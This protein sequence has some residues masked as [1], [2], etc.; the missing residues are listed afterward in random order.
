[1]IDRV[2]GNRYRIVERIGIGGMA[3]VYRAT[4]EVL[5]RTVAVKVMLPQYAADPTFAARFKQ[6]AQAAANLQS[7]Y[8]VSI[9]D[10]GR[11]DTDETYYIVM[12]LVRGTDLK[13]AINQRG[14]LN[15]RKAAEI[16]SQVCS[17]LS[18]AHAYDIIHRD[19]KPHNIMVQPDGNAKV[20]DFGIA[21]ANGSSMTQTGSVLGTAYYVSP[22]QAQGR[23]LTAATDLYSLGIVLYECV[24]GKLPFEGPDAVAVALKQVNQAPA[25]P[26][27]LNADL[28]ADLEAI[29]LKAMAKDPA[30]R[31]ST[32]EAMRLALNNY[33]AGRPIDTGLVDPQAETSVIAAANRKVNRGDSRGENRGEARVSATA[34]TTVLRGERGERAGGGGSERGGGGSDRSGSER[35]SG[36][37]PE[38]EITRTTIMP[39]APVSA[40]GDLGLVTSL[41][42]TRKKNRNR[43]IAVGV[44]VCVVI[45]GLVA[46][47]VFKSFQKNT[48]DMVRVP[49]V[50][51]RTEADAIKTLKDA[52]FEVGET[53]YEYSETVDEG[54]VISTNPAARELVDKGSEVDLVVSKGKPE[55][56]Q[57][58]VP[59]VV[60][61]TEEEARKKIEDAGFVADR[62]EEFSST[63]EAGRITR[64]DPESDKMAKTGTTITYWVSKGVESRTVP[65]VIG[66]PYDEAVRILY[67]ENFKVEKVRTE[68]S[69]T[70]P[71]D[72]VISQDP[73]SGTTQKEGTVIKL[74][75]SDGPA[76]PPPV[77]I[78]DIV[79]MTP[80]QAGNTLGNLGLYVDIVYV[81]TSIP[82]EVGK[83]LYCDPGVDSEVQRGTTVKLAVGE[84]PPDPPDPPPV[85]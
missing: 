52:G 68:Y 46:M 62:D 53:T 36:G 11:D 60:G 42:E 23:E 34:A 40:G 66:K 26:S 77:K 85:P 22:E 15:Q 14:P 76:P 28:D 8:I 6:E 41:E 58:Q 59:K 30:E 61:L 37:S 16:A 38:R 5:G 63:V 71:K 27:E 82:S 83:V 31:Y 25:P 47:L 56:D 72:C 43:A 81:E 75:V 13:S 74:V 7:P 64:Q 45:L 49:T 35:G 9:Y 24:T 48:P 17:A 78:P 55:P 84:A 2:F 4:D 50:I 18:V 69:D 29:I 20:M 39:A 33:L 21:R 19:I 32:A 80:A 3:E 51:Q 65:Y 67:D 54:K 12:E 1:V 70:V 44:L 79:G 73:T 10:W 57:V